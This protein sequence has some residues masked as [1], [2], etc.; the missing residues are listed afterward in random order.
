MRPRLLILILLT[1]TLCWATNTNAQKT[2][3]YGY[4]NDKTTKEP[5]IAASIYIPEENLSTTTNEKG[6]YTIH[7]KN[8]STHHLKIAHLA[9]QSLEQSLEIKHEKTLQMNFELSPQNHQLEEVIIQAGK[10][11]NIRKIEMS[12]QKLEHKTLKKIPALMGE[13]DIL[14]ALML[15][16]GVQSA[17]EGTSAFS[18]RGGSP[19]QNLIL[20]DQATIYNASHLMGF[21]SVFNNDVIQD[22]K[23]YKGDIPPAYGGRLSSVIDI[24]TKYPNDENL[25][26]SGGIGLIS[27][28]IAIETPIVKEKL[29]LM[30]AARRTYADLFLP[31][32]KDKNLQESILHFY[33]LNG[34]LHYKPS[35][36][37]RITLSTYYGK[38]KFGQASM[39]SMQFSN[40]SHTLKW[41]HQ[42]NSKLHTNIAIL[43][44]RYDYKLAALL[45][46]Y[47]L[48]WKSNINTLGIRAE[49]NY[50]YNEKHHLKFGISSNYHALKPNESY[51]QPP[52]SQGVQFILPTQYA[53]ENAIFAMNEQ[54]IN[55]RI[56]IKY[57]LRLTSIHN[58]GPYTHYTLDNN[59]QLT[60]DSIK[61]KKGEIFNT[62]FG[63]EPRLG[64]II[65]LAENNAI[66]AS[67]ARTMQFL[68]LVSNS[69]AGSPLD[70]WVPASPNLKPQKANQIAIGY[71][72]NLLNDAIETSVEV[73]Y[74]HLTN[75]L[76]LKDHASI[77]LNDR[78]E[79]EFRTGIGRSYGVE[80]MIRK[81]IGRF[82]GWISYT[83]ARSFRKVDDINQN[84]WYQTTFDRPHNLN[85]V[86]NYDLTKRINLAASWTYATGTPTTFPEGR[87][88]VDG[89]YLP[90]YADR[91]TYR[92]DDY[93]RLDL[94]ATFILKKRRNYQHDLNLSL[95]NAYARHNT[96]YLQFQEEPIGSSNMFA[97]KIYLFSIVPSI[98]YNFKF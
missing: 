13:I 54:K 91:N 65:Q 93:H 82:S 75:V 64:A 66:K 56:A 38:D 15:L 45:S 67:Y 96:W 89:T 48:Q 24:N 5:L 30:T 29:S 6:F 79:A 53:L 27:S 87:F 23:L 94:A 2:K 59:Y 25:K 39:S 9:Y 17:A 47:D 37:D 43:N 78:L 58:I 55:D 90:I 44:S 18:V 4:I 88:E 69:A 8:S 92:L 16:P 72:H 84:K 81:N 10:K 85:I 21:F 49:L 3:L 77:I 12:V 60:G 34:S 61:Y 74:K 7:L 31:L 83:Y 68:H 71:F 63:F 1:Q 14:K 42:Y 98:T 19:D 46:N 32:A 26:I 33:D 73:F 36:K 41:Q 11:D 51:S 28:R 76:D 80:T 52:N 86:A 40:Q 35:Q 20:L 97:N 22:I 50:Q 70:I 57:G 95:Y 62:Y